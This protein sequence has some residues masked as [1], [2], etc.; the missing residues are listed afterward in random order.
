M[1]TAIQMGSV[2]NNNITAAL[3]SNASGLY[4]LLWETTKYQRNKSTI[5]KV[6]ICFKFPVPQNEVVSSI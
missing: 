2:N 3:M 4:L 5:H 6:F 1:L